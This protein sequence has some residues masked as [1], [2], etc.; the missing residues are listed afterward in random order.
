[1]LKQSLLL[2]WHLLRITALPFR[3]RL[4][5]FFSKTW[6]LLALGLQRRATVRIG[7]VSYTAT[8]LSALG[9]LQSS[10]VDF[11]RDVVTTGI[12]SETHPTVKDIGA[13]IGQFTNA[14]KL[15]Y[16]QAVIQAFEPDPNT[17][18]E[19][20]ANTR[21]L[22][23]LTLRNVGLGNENTQKTLYIQRFSVMSSFRPGGNARARGLPTK[24]VRVR[25]LDDLERPKDPTSLMKIDVEGFEMEVVKGAIRTLADTKYLLIEVG[26]N[27]GSTDQTNLALLSAIAKAVPAARIVKFGRPL[28]ALDRPSC[29]DVLIQ[30]NDT[31]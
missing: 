6:V 8:T 1:M 29:Q 15:F 20:Q 31:R 23:N 25:R 27:R 13:N 2:D 19:L 7:P 3:W 28:G 10:I 16:P 22:T 26:L 14:V 18:A 24:K 5:F 9:T 30:L 4:Q 11:H 21:N 17:F 12:I